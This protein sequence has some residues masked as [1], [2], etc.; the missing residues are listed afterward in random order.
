MQQK[1]QRM[2][3]FMQ[4]DSTTRIT[5]LH[6]KSKQQADL[7]AQQLLLSE[8]N[9][10]RQQFQQKQKQLRTEQQVAASSTLGSSR[11]SVLQEKDK[12]IQVVLQK[13]LE[14]ASKKCTA[15]AVSKLALQAC[16]IL[17]IKECQV[18]CK[19]DQFEEIKK[20]LK[21]NNIE[22]KKFEKELSEDSKGGC[23][24]YNRNCNVFIE[25]T[26]AKRVMLAYKGKAPEANSILFEEASLLW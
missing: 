21:T 4:Q 20:F 7:A 6:E 22:C 12:V 2:V 8:T 17:D 9:K 11:F 10:A 3:E 14:A 16:G 15:Q 25:N 26:I 24:I 18:Q 19:S 23:I 5:E 1:I 13:A